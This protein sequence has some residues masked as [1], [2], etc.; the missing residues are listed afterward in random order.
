MACLSVAAEPLAFAEPSA[1]VDPPGRACSPGTETGQLPERGPKLE[2]KQG[3]VRVRPP[4]HKRQSDKQML[5]AALLA[6]SEQE[7]E[8]VLKDLARMGKYMEAIVRGQRCPA[9]ESTEAKELGTSG[10]PA[11][12]NFYSWSTPELMLV[13]VNNA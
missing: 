5:A 3:R 1:V 7:R 8:E 13:N 2:P 12:G 11:L 9:S 4:K 6:T 10:G